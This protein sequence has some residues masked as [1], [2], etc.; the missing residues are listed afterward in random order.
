[1]HGI[2][3]V[4]TGNAG[5][6]QEI[7]NRVMQGIMSMIASALPPDP[8]TIYSFYHWKPFMEAL[9]AKAI[10]KYLLMGLKPQIFSPVNN[11]IIRLV[12]TYYASI[13]LGMTGNLNCQKVALTSN[14]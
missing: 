3:S 14:N 13:I 9:L 6:S 11:L 4:A 10:Q 2:W 7:L 5:K 8:C 12:A 1:M